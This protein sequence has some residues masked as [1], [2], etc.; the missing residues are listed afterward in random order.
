MKIFFYLALISFSFANNFY[1]VNDVTIGYDSNPMKLSKNELNESVGDLFL[2]KYSINTK[3]I[4]FYSKLRTSFSIFDRKTK[5]SLGLKLNKYLDLDEKTNYGVYFNSSQ[6]LG[7]FQTIKFTYTHIPDIFLRQYD[8]ADAI[9]QYLNNLTPEAKA[10]KCYFNLSKASLYYEF[11]FIDRKNKAK[12]GYSNETHYYNQYFTE[13]DLDI[14]GFQ[15]AFFGKMNSGSYDLSYQFNNADNITFL[16]GNVSTSQ[17]DRSYSERG[18]KI[19]LNKKIEKFSLGVSVDNKKRS[20]TSTLL[21]DN[22]HRSRTHNDKTISI[23]FK[24]K[25]NNLNHKVKLSSRERNTESPYGWVEDLK[26][27]KRYDLSYTVYFKKILL[28]SHK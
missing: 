16:N 17:M 21:T 4:K 7:G 11:P 20:F 6:P 23:S 27:F 25:I 12:I 5:V 19:S 10:K 15:I 8:D 26:T 3:Y 14:K 22:L 13:F 24:Y 28:G 1:L 2:S 18:Y 9:H